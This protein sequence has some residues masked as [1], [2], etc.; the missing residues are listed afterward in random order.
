M[1]AFVHNSLNEIVHF[2]YL[3]FSNPIFRVYISDAN[4]SDVKL[5]LIYRVD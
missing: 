5:I 2:N 1:N 4:E 3:V